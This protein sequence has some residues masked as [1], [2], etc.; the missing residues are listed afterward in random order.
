[1]VILVE[2][3]V[4]SGLGYYYIHRFSA[5]LDAA[6]ADKVQLPGL[7]MNRQLL[8]YE[9]VAD[10]AMMTEL[11]GEEFIDGQVVG[12]DGSIYY[13]LNPSDVGRSIADMPGLAA[14]SFRK[15]LSAAVLV[16][17]EED[18]ETFLISITPIAAYEGGLPFF[19]AYVKVGTNLTQAKK[20][21]IIKTFVAGSLL[22]I[23]L[24]SLAILAFSRRLVTRPIARLARSADRL[25]QGSLDEAIAVQRNDEIGGLARS[26]IA[27]RDAIRTQI[28]ELEAANR[29]LT[30]LDQMK[31][32]FLSSVSHELRTPLTALLGYAKLSSRAFQKYFL[33]Q[34][35]TDPI[36]AEKGERIRGNLE[37]I[38]ME[39]ERLRRMINDV[40]DLHKIE[41]GGMEWQLQELHP[42]A[43][44]EHAAAVVEALFHAPGDSGQA[45]QS[46][47]PTLV[48]DVRPGLPPVLGDPDRIQ[49]VC[50]NLLHNAAK[51]TRVGT[52]TLRA[53]Q[54]PATDG[55]VLF[56]VVDTG[57]GIAPQDRDKVFGKFQQLRGTDTLPD[58]PCGTG[59]G[60]AIS[61][62]IVEHHGGRIW[63]ESE[64]GK[65]SV[66]SFTLPVAPRS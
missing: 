35:T 27:M 64:L 16:A 23:V 7:L 3:L 39:G 32:S 47:R 43:I 52:V 49:Q 11:V 36:L 42:G 51:F 40:L 18:G 62:E 53:L 6:V 20:A 60:L 38:Q 29:R 30:E 5:E 58:T 48:L 1:M 61:R 19:F 55:Q 4:L 21:T 54:D 59:L 26:F 46:G 28:A 25:A 34:T 66:F 12:S 57:P 14:R 44:A 45:E 56:Q 31:S 41:S 24:S 65:G 13:A 22:C 33:P 10:K 2:T 15:N 63:V 9:S 17:Q 8:R 50:I 37:I